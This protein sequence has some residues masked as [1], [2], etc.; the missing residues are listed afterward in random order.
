VSS[1]LNID[2]FT[3]AGGSA[4]TITGL[5][6][7]PATLIKAPSTN[8]SAVEIGVGNFTAGRGYPLDP[9]EFVST[10]A[11]NP[12]TLRVRGVTGQKLSFWQEVP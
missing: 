1:T 11:I 5:V 7:N 10:E 4:E 2:T 3:L 8:T 12:Q 9:G 6:A